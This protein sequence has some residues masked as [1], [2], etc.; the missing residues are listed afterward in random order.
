MPEVAAAIEA[1]APD[2][3]GRVFWEE[4]QLP[5]P[6]TLQ[7]NQLERLIGPMKPTSLTDGVRATIEH[8]RREA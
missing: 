4:D 3:A 8:F 5:F 6:E 2:V 7:G 1:A